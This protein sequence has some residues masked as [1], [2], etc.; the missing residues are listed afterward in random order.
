M[1]HKYLILFW[2]NKINNKSTKVLLGA[3]FAP[4]NGIGNHIH[5]IK[6]FCCTSIMLYPSDNIINKISAHQFSSILKQTKNN[7][8]LKKDIVLHSHVYPDFI[9]HCERLQ[10][11]G[12]KWIHTYHAPYQKEYAKDD[13]LDW[14]KEFN[15]VWINT[16]SKADIKISVSKWQQ[17]YL[18]TNHNIETI[19]LP[20]GVDVNLCDKGNGD[21]FKKEIGFDNFILNVS[22]HDPVKNSGEFVQLAISMPNKQFVIIGPGLSNDIFISEYNIK[23]PANLLIYGPASHTKVQDAIAACEVLVSCAKKE[24]LPTLVLEGMA[25]EKP[26]IVSNEPGSME[27]ISHGKYGYF[28]ELGNINDLQQKTILALNDTNKGQLARQRVLEE[29]DWKVVAKKLDQIYQNI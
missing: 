14:Q 25:H 2:F 10:K 16:A 13:L 7:F 1:Y 20:N 6:Q 22:R 17:E 24:G 9:Y 8:L 23:V 27:A 28:Y 5:S 19:Y 3:N 4:N 26:V 29:Y 11:L 15:N 21:R 18:K 12:F